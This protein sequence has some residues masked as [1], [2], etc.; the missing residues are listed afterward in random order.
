MSQSDE[1]PVLFQAVAIMVVVGLILT[2]VGDVWIHWLAIGGIALVSCWAQQ[3]M[4]KRK[5]PSKRK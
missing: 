5:K 4:G 3:S 2:V 1:D